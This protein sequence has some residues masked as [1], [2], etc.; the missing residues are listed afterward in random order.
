M[1]VRVI[2]AAAFAIAVPCFAAQA[3]MSVH[4]RYAAELGLDASQYTLNQIVQI[5]DADAA[6]G[7]RSRRIEV[8]NRQNKAF[9]DR[10][11]SAGLGGQNPV[12]A[13][14]SN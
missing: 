11:H 4:E 13:T 5:K 6:N 9:W 2:F 1:S 7:E 14:G 8:I 12:I 3:E 10:V